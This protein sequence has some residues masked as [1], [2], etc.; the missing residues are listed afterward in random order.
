[1][2][3]APPS[4]AAPAAAGRR[5]PDGLADDRF[6]SGGGRVSFVS[7]ARDDRVD[8]LVNDG[9]RLYIRVASGGGRAFFANG[10]HCSAQVLPRRPRR[11]PFCLGAGRASC[12]RGVHDDLVDD[13]VNDLVDG[14]RL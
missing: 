8:D 14:E 10:V 7:G 12:A 2:A 9:E 1:M 5:F 13:L 6:A 4:R 3:A 11:R